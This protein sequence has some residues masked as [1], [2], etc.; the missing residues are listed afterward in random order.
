MMA[1][2]QGYYSER[3][4]Y[5]WV[6]VDDLEMD[7]LETVRDA[8]R[9]NDAD[10]P[11]LALKDSEL[12]RAARLYGRD[13]VT[14]EHGFNLAAVALLGKEDAILDVMPLY[15]TDAVLQRVEN[16]RYDDR[17]IC[18]GSEANLLSLAIGRPFDRCTCCR[19]LSNWK[20][21]FC[22]PLRLEQC[23]QSA[24]RLHPAYTSRKSDRCSDRAP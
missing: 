20:V 10:Y 5:P 19:G 2:K 17:L 7:L 3:T 15:R 22:L 1:R 11:W 4:V 6:T 13:Q 12:L 18:R 8:L 9:A 23:G 14:G 21:R 16:D 24:G